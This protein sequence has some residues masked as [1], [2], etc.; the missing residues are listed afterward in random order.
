MTFREAA[1]SAVAVRT[2]EVFEFEEGALDTSDIERL[3]DMRVATRRLRAVMEI[4]APC[5]P[6]AEHRQ[7]LKDVKA[8]AHALEVSSSAW[9]RRPGPED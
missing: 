8:L 1:A 7:A 6:K 3:H 5:F 2:E 4:F 9:V